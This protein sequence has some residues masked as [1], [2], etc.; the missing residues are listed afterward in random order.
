METVSFFRRRA[1]LIGLAILCVVSPHLGMAA[2][3]NT[4]LVPVSPYGSGW[5]ELAY[6]AAVPASAAANTDEPSV[7]ALGGFGIMPDEVDWYLNRYA[8]ANTYMI[9]KQAEWSEGHWKLNE[10]GGSVAYDVSANSNDGAITGAVWS[11]DELTFDGSGDYV[12]ATGYKGVAGTANRTVSAWIKT[13]TDGVVLSWG[14]A[15]NDGESWVLMVQDGHVCVDIGG[16]YKEGSTNVADNAWRHIAAKLDSSGSPSIANIT[17]YVDGNKETVV[18]TYDTAGSSLAS[19]LMGYWKLNESSGGTAEDSS[20]WDKDGTLMTNDALGVQDVGPDWDAGGKLGG[21]LYFDE[22]HQNWVDIADESHFDIYNAFSISLWARHELPSNANKGIISKGS[23]YNSGWHSE[24]YAG[25]EQMMF[26]AREASDTSTYSLTGSA[27]SLSDGAWEHLVYVFDYTTTGYMY[28]YVNGSLDQSC[29]VDELLKAN[30]KPL[31]LGCKAYGDP[32]GFFN[33]HLDEIAFWDRAITSTEISSLYNSGNGQEISLGSTSLDTAAGEDARIGIFS[34][35][36]DFSGIIE[37]VMIYDEALTDDEITEMCEM[38]GQSYAGIN[39]ITESSLDAAV[40]YLAQT[41]WTTT[42]SEVVLCDENDFAG[43]LAAS[44]LAGRLEVPLLFFDGSAGLSSAALNIIDNDLQCAAALTV[45]GNSTVTNQLSGIGVS[46]TSLASAN[47]ILGWMVNNDLPVDY[48]AL[49]NPNDRTCGKVLKSSITAALMATARGGAV[50]PLAYDTVWKEIFTRTG[51]TYSQPSGAPESVTGKWLLGTLTLDGYSYDYVLACGIQDPWYDKANIDF[52]DDGDYGDAGE[53]PFTSADTVTIGGKDYSITVGPYTAG[54]V[55]FTYPIISEIKTDLSSYY[56]TLGQAFPEYIC[57]TGYFD[58]IPPAIENNAGTYVDVEDIPNDHVLGEIDSDAFQDA[59]VGRIVG[60]SLL[61]TTLLGARSVTYDDLVGNPD[62]WANKAKIL[63]GHGFEGCR[64]YMQ[65]KLEN[66]GFNVSEYL[67]KD[68]SIEEIPTDWMVNMGAIVQEDHGGA[69]GIGYHIGALLPTEL[70]YATSPYIVEA[71]GCVSA[72]IDCAPLGE[73]G[74]LRALQKGAI[75]W[76]GTMRGTPG[77]KQQSR[78]EI[79]TKLC[80]GDMTLGQAFRDALHMLRLWDL[81]GD[82]GYSIYC[83]RN[84]TLYGDPALN[85]YTPAAPSIAPAYLAVNG[86]TLTATGPQTWWYD[87]QGSDPESY[88][89]HGPGLTGQPDLHKRL[90]GTRYKTYGTITNL[91]QEA[92]IASVLG[93]PSGTAYIDEQRDGSETA[94]WRCRMIDYDYFDGI[95]DYQDNDI[96]YTV[97]VSGGGAVTAT[98]LNSRP[99]NLTETS[100]RLNGLLRYTGAETGDADPTVTIYW[101]ENDGGTTAANWDYSEAIGAKRSSEIFSADISGLSSGATYYF[102]CCAANSAGDGWAAATAQFVT[103]STVTVTAPTV[104]NSVATNITSD[105]ARLNGQVTDTGGENPTVT[106]YWGDNDGGKTPVNWD[107]SEAMG[108]QGGTFFKDISGLNPSAT[109]YFRC[110]ASNSAGSDWADATLQF[111]T[112]APGIV[113]V[114]NGD[115]ETIYKP[116]STTISATLSTGSWTQGVGPNCPIDSGQYEFSDETS[117][118]FADIPGW[119][120][121]DRD[122]WIALGGTYGRDQTTGD[123]QG[124]V[125]NQSNHTAGGA[126][127]YL[128]NGGGWGNPAGGLI[129]SQASLG[130]I[131]SNATYTL[132]MYAKG[133]ATPVVLN[134]LADGVVVTPSSSVSPTLTAEFQEFSRTYDAIDLSVYVGQAITIVCGVDRNASGNQTQM[135]DVSLAYVAGS[136]DTDPPTP[137]PA[138]FASPPAADSDTAISMTATTGS[139]ASGPVEYF[140][141]ETSGNPGGS[142]SGWQTSPSYTDSGLDAGTQYTYT[143]TMR[144]ALLNT[145]AASSPAGATTT[146]GSTEDNFNVTEDA[147]ITQKKPDDNYGSDSVLRVRGD[148]STRETHSYLKFTVSGVGTV[149]SAKLKLWSIDVNMGVDVYQAASNSWSEGSIIWNTAPGTTGG[150]LDSVGVTTGWTEFD[151]TSAITGDGTYSF[152]LQGNT[153]SPGRDFSSSEGS[154]IPVLTITHQ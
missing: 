62:D 120:G 129:V 131:Q 60:N 154:Y 108:T 20:L 10:G 150:A 32:E 58:T 26:K 80:S 8:P 65:R 2:G 72:G 15:S 47:E 79:W 51:T 1:I 141:D 132:S 16:A 21:C 124:S 43:A 7:I 46:Q 140:F 84:L 122:G 145:G 3:K 30:D 56:T 27:G 119:L 134:L 92:G 93:W 125:S 149:T 64:H 89:W 14:H 54:D 78:H 111:E 55:K 100:A 35:S 138:T 148:T 42:T 83:R 95:V 146:G 63:V 49:C 77:L 135:D 136:G 75:A 147:Y 73:C 142:D 59:A 91:V 50:I 5:E 143:V 110:Y 12:T 17:L 40:C 41:F 19:G 118:A 139:D 101:G 76:M 44:A 71:G 53:G 74:S 22:D 153:D 36:G 106:I 66:V 24:Q 34:G 112:Q 18:E 25:T 114:P 97:T 126:N 81:E 57:I 137:N 87:I 6:L 37:D 68:I 104:V 61:A 13:S 45:S 29:E 130:D 133:D 4:F 121:Y 11:G 102:R 115:F 52:N 151:V 9:N 113:T 48:F 99:T 127:C 123:L 28:L 39:I 94:T 86:S 69:Q 33:G 38:A 85:P 105:A 88:L 98:V 152:V 70:Q 116:G 67:L 23:G 103:P 109:Y 128:S 144:D 90:L 82:N 117:G 31:R 96:N 107:N